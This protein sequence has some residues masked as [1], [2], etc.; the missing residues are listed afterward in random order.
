MTTDRRSVIAGIAATV[1][2]R[3]AQTAGLP[4]ARWEQGAVAGM[5]VLRSPDFFTP[6]A[7]RVK[8]LSKPILYAR[9]TGDHATSPA[10]IAGLLAARARMPTIPEAGHFIHVEQPQALANLLVG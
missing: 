2:P 8:D 5:A 1:L 9:G 7:A 3:L 10:E 4:D 6:V